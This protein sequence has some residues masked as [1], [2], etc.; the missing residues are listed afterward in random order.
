MGGG[1]TVFRADFANKP[2]RGRRAF[3]AAKLRAVA[4]NPGWSVDGSGSSG[5]NGDVTLATPQPPVL[6]PLPLPCEPCSA[7]SH[8]KL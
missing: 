6:H 1:R 8:L 2:L 5:H 4:I 3:G 7:L